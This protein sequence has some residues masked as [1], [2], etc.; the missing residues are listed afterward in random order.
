MPFVLKIGPNA[1]QRMMNEV[2]GS[3]LNEFVSEYIDDLIIYLKSMQYHVKYSQLV[4]E[5]LNE[6]EIQLNMEKS[7]FAKWS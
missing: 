3:Y 2:L 7:E 6:Y 1:F 5:R 4:A